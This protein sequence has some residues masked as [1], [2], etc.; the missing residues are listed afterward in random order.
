MNQPYP[1]QRLAGSTV[2]RARAHLMSGLSL[3]F[4]FDTPWLS[5]RGVA[6]TPA[7]LPSSGRF[8]QMWEP[9]SSL[10]AELLVELRQIECEAERTDD[11]ARRRDD[12]RCA[13]DRRDRGED[14]ANLVLV[15]A[16]VPRGGEVGEIG[17]G[18][19]VDRDERGDAD[20]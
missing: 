17:D 8:N 7:G 9:G 19:C 15:D 4:T 13:D 3:S 2:A 14:P 11:V 6:S 10:V 12:P 20:E 1:A 5:S 16:E 18:R